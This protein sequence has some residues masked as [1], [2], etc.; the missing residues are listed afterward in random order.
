M[1]DFLACF[2]GYDNLKVDL[3]FFFFLFFSFLA[4]VKTAKVCVR[5]CVRALACVSALSEL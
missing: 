2:S 5:A 1:V 4:R 3:A